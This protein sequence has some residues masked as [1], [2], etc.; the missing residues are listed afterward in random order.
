MATTLNDGRH[1]VILYFFFCLKLSNNA[2][3]I[4]ALAMKLD[5]LIMDEPASVFVPILTAFHF[6]FHLIS[7]NYEL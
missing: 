3:A 6:L 5:V 7:F 4:R 1:F 2:C